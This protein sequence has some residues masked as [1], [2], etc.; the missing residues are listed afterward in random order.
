MKRMIS[1]S[2]LEAAIVNEGEDAA[3]ALKKSVEVAKH[4]E[5]LG[6]E[7]L[8][9]AEHH[10]M[11]GIASS[12]TAV[13]IGHIAENTSTLRV[14]AGGIMLPNHSPLVIAEQFGT[15]TSLYP[16]RIDLGLGR[17]PGSDQLTARA[18]RRNNMHVVYHF[19]DDIKELQQ[20]LS[21]QNKGAKVRAFPG[22]GLDIPI[23][24]LG[25]STDS[26]HL[27]A[28][29]GLPYAFAAHFSPEQCRT[30]ISIYKEE[31]K[32]SANLKEPYAIACVNVI[33]ADT[34]DEAKYLVTSLYQMFMGIVTGQAIKLPPPVA[35]MDSI[36]TQ[37]IEY[38]VR[39]R[40]YYTFI[41]DYLTLRKNLTEF[42]EDIGVDEIM[43]ATYIFD[44]QKR[45]NSFSVLKKAIPQ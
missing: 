28:S 15:L 10:N 14:G 35:S 25:S 24:V 19:A 20:Y 3:S 6:Y 17:A 5:Q 22:E 40:T 8:W 21:D 42:A 37:E 41:G 13:V 44:L 23:W 29:L 33:G 32:P 4:V 43:A 39:S 36:W 30:A 12:A 11:P 38:V 16:G 9:L 2:A 27:A 26:A 45:L 18:I 7:R 1:L 34:N 31:F